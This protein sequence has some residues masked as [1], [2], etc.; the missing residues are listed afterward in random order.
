MR[1]LIVLREYR[2]KAF[3]RR[4]QFLE[5]SDIVTGKLKDILAGGLRLCF[6]P[7]GG[8]LF[9]WSISRKLP[10]AIAATSGF[11]ETRISKVLK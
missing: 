6:C 4:S 3:D 9:T 10:Q 5:E 1:D 7:G 2:G 11:A 8:P